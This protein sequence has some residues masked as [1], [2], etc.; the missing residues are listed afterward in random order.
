MKNITLIAILFCT[1]HSLYAQQG[2]SA[3]NT[4]VEA[5]MKSAYSTTNFTANLN[6]GDYDVLYH[7]L[8]FEVD[9]AAY[10]IDGEVTTAFTAKQNMPDI[11]FDLTSQ[12]TV[13]EVT[14]NGNALIFE[15]N[16]DDE[17]IITFQSA[18]SQGSEATVTIT[19]SGLPAFGDGSFAID[20]HNGTPSLW[21]LS[22]PYGAKD[23]W[24]CKQDLNDKID[25]IDVYI[26]APSEYVSVSNGVEQSETDNGDGTTTTHFQHNYP[27]PA[28]LIAIAVTNY[29]IYN[30]TA[31]TA[32]NTFPI[33]NYIYPE[34]VPTAIPEL[35]NTL[36]AMNL[37]EDLFE[38]YPYHNEKYGHAQYGYGGGMEHTTVSFMGG[39]YR[40][41]IAHELAH[42]WFGNKVTCGSWKD[43]WLNE[44]FATYLSGLLV[45]HMDGEEAFTTWKGNRTESITSQPGGSVYLT[46]TDTTSIS[47]IFSSRL[48]YNKGAMVVHMLRFKMGD[49]DFYQGLKNYLADPELA[50][51]YAVTPQLENHLEAASGMDLTE[52]FQDWV[53]REGYPSYSITTQHFGE[54][55]VKI[56]INQTQSHASVNYFEMPV[57]IRLFG[58]GGAVQDVVLDN[59]FNGQEYVIAVPFTVTGFQFDPK[60]DLISANNEIFLG[61]NRINNL[62]NVTLYPNPAATRLHLQLPQGIVL[63]KA[64]FYNML[65]Q[66]VMESESQT[67]WNITALSPGVHFVTLTTDSGTKQLRFIK[68]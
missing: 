14:M 68:E 51:G 35:A 5:E 19:Y 52:F 10:F 17:L 9:P 50:F 37:F 4:I 18:I 41:L 24:P 34:T 66:K 11:T 25:N 56:T 30:Q 15:Q 57:P 64:I 44:G 13:S 65:G 21:T 7:E 43:I 23:W 59:T 38:T 26:T 39:F 6:T 63:Q 54:G 32:P 58:D 45:E 3:F 53:Y 31:G 42:Q 33:V 62:A 40:E 29:S 55:Q 1:I 20:T 28:Y 27:I 60:N 8:H 16:T 61:T 2:N 36:T 46:D 67:S 22:Q 12:L 48:T 47:R 49:T